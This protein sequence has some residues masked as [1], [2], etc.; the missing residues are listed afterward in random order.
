MGMYRSPHKK[1]PRW[2]PN[3]D[4]IVPFG[5]KTRTPNADGLKPGM[6]FRD[7]K[8]GLHVV[9]DKGRKKRPSKPA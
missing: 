6:T 7:A 2:K 1:R 3:A 9:P 8:G 5:K 4:F